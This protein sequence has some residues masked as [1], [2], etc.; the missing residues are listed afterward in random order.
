MSAVNRAFLPLRVKLTMWSLG[1]FLM[2]FVVIATTWFVLKREIRLGDLDNSLRRNAEYA[3]RVLILPETSIR[4]KAELDELASRVSR[5]ALF[6][7]YFVQIR[8]DD[9]GLYSSSS[10][11]KSLAS[12]DLPMNRNS[13]GPEFDTVPVALDE[14]THAALRVITVPFWNE[15]GQRFHLQLATPAP[16]SIDPQAMLFDLALFSL[17]I[18]LLAAGA[19]A[20]IMAGRVVSPIKRL[21]KAACSVSPTSLRER[22]DVG[23][24]DSEIARLQHE[25]KTPVAVLLSQAQVLKQEDRTAFEY[26]RFL[27]VVEEEMRI[28]GRLVES[29]LVLARIG[30]GKDLV[31]REHVAVN[32]VVLEAA[33]HCA[34]VSRQ[35]EVP[36]VTNLHFTAEGE[37]E[38]ELEGDP[39]LLRTMLENLLRNALRFSPRGEPVDLRVACTK[40]RASITVRDR[41]PGIPREHMEHIF[42]RFYQVPQDSAQT[43]GV[44]LGLAIAK[45]VAELHNGTIGVRNCPDRGCEFDVLLPLAKAQPHAASEPAAVAEAPAPR[46]EISSATDAER[47]AR[48]RHEPGNP[49]LGGSLPG[50][51]AA[52]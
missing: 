42:G 24:E 18:G 22:I 34:A 32:D 50:L 40:D 1:L 36:L 19:A 44:G 49:E 47:S 25:L 16:V 33:E 10:V 26:R 43:R 46:A 17:P 6:E 48:K 51:S 41:G 9:G 29:F 52:E 35:H 12:V 38:P 28:L 7:R 11:E 30:H 45:S 15:L 5:S 31:R 13:A 14:N 20:W 27:A 4:S 23:P 39:E 8:S 21:A 37:S 2:I 3:V